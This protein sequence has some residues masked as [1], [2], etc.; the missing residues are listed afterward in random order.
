[1][2]ARIYRRIRLLQ[3]GTDIELMLGRKDVDMDVLA[4]RQQ[5]RQSGPEG[6]NGFERTGEADAFRSWPGKPGCV[7]SRPLRRHTEAE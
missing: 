3:C 5:L 7:V 6:G 2:D 4:L 1:M